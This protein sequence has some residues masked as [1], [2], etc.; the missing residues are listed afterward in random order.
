MSFSASDIVEIIAQ[1][2]WRMVLVGALCA[3]AIGWLMW[4]STPL[5]EART[6]L[7]YKLGSEYLYFPSDGETTPGVRAPDPGDL[8]QIIGAEMQIVVNREL[9]RRL[10]AEIGVL[11]VFPGF[12]PEAADSEEWLDTGAEMLRGMVTVGLVPNTQMV[13][14]R[15]RHGDPVIAAELANGLVDLYLKSRLEIFT[16]RDSEYFRGRLGLA[17][18]QARIVENRI[19]ALLGDVDP[20][21]FETEQEILISRQSTL[22]REIADIESALVGAQATKASL[23]RELA[24]MPETIV[25]YREIQ[26]NPVIVAAENRVVVLEAERSAIIA[27]LG[28]THPSVRT[29][30]RE[31]EALRLAAQDKEAQVEVGSRIISNPMWLRARTQFE[32]TLTRLRE[33]EARREHLTAELQT[34]S[35]A[36]AA[37]AA[38]AS[39]LAALEAAAE[40]QR[41]QVSHFDLRLSDSLAEETQGGT[42]LGSV[43]ILERA[44]PVLAPVG[45]PRSVKMIL[46]VIVG[47]F[48]GVAAGALA[49]F[50]RMTVLST[51][52]LE[53]RLGAP[54]LAELGVVRPRRRSAA[55]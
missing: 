19:R 54:A 49:Y 8:S 41:E 7:L 33:L 34:N 50:S 44:Q 20:L 18:E 31:I 11:R 25:E 9:R 48:I 29:L 16:Q 35:A 53:Q 45:P 12:P 6:L 55:H 43:R 37:K 5:Y 39:E 52:M 26:R 42:P 3:G 30:E 38:I 51:H 1:Q 36:L 27:T 32:E 21:L 28:R 13:D 17:K 47:G 46:A 15:M 22:Q 40:R 14:I 10:I 4:S 23:E 24:G 2:F